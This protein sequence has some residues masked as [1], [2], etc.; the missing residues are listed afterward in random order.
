MRT[1]VY[2][3]GFN[4]F[5]GRLSKTRFKWLNVCKFARAVCDQLGDDYSN[6]GEPFVRYYTSPIKRA[7]ST[8]PES[9]PKNQNDYLLALSHICGEDLE[10][11]KGRF[12][13]CKFWAYDA[14]SGAPTVSEQPKPK[15]RVW[16]LE[17]KRVDVKLGSDLISDAVQ[18]R[19]SAQVIVSN[20]EDIAPAIETT[21]ALSPNMKIGLVTPSQK[22]AKGGLTRP[23][24]QLLVKS[25]GRNDVLPFVNDSIL[26]ECR[27]ST[28][29][30]RQKRHIR[31]PDDWS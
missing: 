2:I 3:D 14:Q 15:V 25:T 13:H 22:N 18:G 11:Y 23:P 26:A 21:I 16:R 4:F 30:R 10:I 24:N 31:C 5:N 17:E 8:S 12:N 27:L 1:Y 19:A 28:P 29:V 7:F 9:A 20:D 6:N